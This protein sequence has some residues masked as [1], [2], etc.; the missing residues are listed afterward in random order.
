MTTYYGVWSGQEWWGGAGVSGLFRTTEIA[1]ANA[2]ALAANFAVRVNQYSGVHW[3]VRAI[4]EDGLPVPNQPPD[5]ANDSMAEALGLRHFESIPEDRWCAMC[6]KPAME[7]VDVHVKGWMCDD[8]KVVKLGCVPKD[9][10]YMF[11][12]QVGHWVKELMP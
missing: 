2:Q 8:H 1:V 4:G 7:Y 5:E 9:D 12:T 6:S 10:E 11:D 3:E